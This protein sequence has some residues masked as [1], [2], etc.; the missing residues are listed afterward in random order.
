MDTI[1]LLNLLEK[2]PIISKMR[3]DVIPAD[4]LMTIPRL[5]HAPQLYIVNTKPSTHPGLHW[6][7]IYEEPYT[8]TIDF[9]DSMGQPPWTYGQYFQNFF[10]NKRFLYSTKPLQGHHET[11]GHF[12][13]YF[14]FYRCRHY[15]LKS[16]V[17]SFSAD[18]SYNDILVKE[19][20]EKNF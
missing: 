19:F 18:K 6:T 4:G 20:V 16:I 15:S 9:W 10:E 17:N 11:C 7:A 13:L 14:A 1:Q 12:C 8:K 5:G 2:D 3:K